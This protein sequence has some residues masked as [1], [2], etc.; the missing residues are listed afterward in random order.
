[1]IR[2]VAF[3]VQGCL[4]TRAL[5]VLVVLL[6][7]PFLRSPAAQAASIIYVDRANPNC[8]NSG[9]GTQTQP[10]CT[11]SAAASKVKAGQTV[12]VSS[13]TYT[14]T[15]VVGVTGTASAPIVFMANPPG[16]VTVTGGT[17]GFKMAG[18]SWITIQGFNVT[19]TSNVGIYASSSNHI[20][21][22][23]NH[24]TF[25][26]QPQD[27]YTKRG[28]LLVDSTSSLVVGN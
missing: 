7:L 12:S 24:V 8:S 26:G 15:V 17:Y 11:I 14:E 18:K 27:G 25:A 20:T 28:I 1:M 21:I 2:S 23:S 9:T 16:S 22:A 6:A 19:Q 3:R 5:A 4:R 10:F 13:G